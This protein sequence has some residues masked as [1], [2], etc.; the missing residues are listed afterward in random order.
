MGGRSA[1]SRNSRRE[2]CNPLL[3]FDFPDEVTATNNSSLGDQFARWTST[4]LECAVDLHPL[5]ITGRR[6]L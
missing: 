2:V 5:I 4:F 3:I 1:N 6:Y